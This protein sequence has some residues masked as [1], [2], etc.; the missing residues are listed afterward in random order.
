MALAKS[1]NLSNLLDQ[2]NAGEV[3]ELNMVFRPM[4]RAV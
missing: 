4:F 1:A 3:K 2:V